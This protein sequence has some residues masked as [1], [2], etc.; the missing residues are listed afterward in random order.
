MVN[1]ITQEAPLGRKARRQRFTFQKINELSDEIA[2]LRSKLEEREAALRARESDWQMLNE[3]L[4]DQ[5]DE[6]QRQSA[7]LQA[8]L[9]DRRLAAERLEMQNQSLLEDLEKAKVQRELRKVDYDRLAAELKA[10]KVERARNDIETWRA[11]G[12]HSPLKRCY[13]KLEGLFRRDRDENESFSFDS[14]LK[15]PPP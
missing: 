7:E 15:L 3:C 6:L 10:I 12:H 5:L 11:V 2:S 13:Q 1:M 9:S 8:E 4:T 14:L